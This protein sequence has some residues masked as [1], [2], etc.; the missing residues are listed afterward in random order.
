MWISPLGFKRWEILTSL[1]S[2]SWKSRKR[3]AK[4]WIYQQEWWIWW[5][6]ELNVDWIWSFLG[7][8]SRNTMDLGATGRFGC[9]WKTGECWV[10]HLTPT[11]LDG[12]MVAN[13]NWSIPKSATQTVMYPCWPGSTHLPEDHGVR[14]HRPMDQIT[15]STN[16]EWTEWLRPYWDHTVTFFQELWRQFADHCAPP[17][18]DC[19][20]WQGAGPAGN[21]ERSEKPQQLLRQLKHQ[22][23]HTKFDLGRSQV[24]PIL[25]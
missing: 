24:E 23:F 4:M 25:C 1:N 13:F 15:K 7:F 14:I 21:R 18:D 5:I 6:N 20:L 2:E 19:W 12:L 22:T 10:H 9:H 8:M 16:I 11:R 3:C 17:C